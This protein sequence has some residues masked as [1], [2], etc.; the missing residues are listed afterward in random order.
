MLAYITAPSYAASFSGGVSYY[1]PHRSNQMTCAHRHLPFGTHL[2][3]HWRGR[4]ISCI[5]NDR[6]PFIRG[7]VLDISYDAARSLGMTGAGVV[8]AQI[9]Y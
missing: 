8:Y 5:V 1:H 2:Q 7:R 6:G 3:V 9:T 4:S